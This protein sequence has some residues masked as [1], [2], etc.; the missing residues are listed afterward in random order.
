MNSLCT[1]IKTW[2]N[3]SQ[4]SRDGIGMNTS[5]RG[6][7]VKLFEQSQVLDTMLYKNM[8]FFSEIT[9]CRNKRP[10]LELTKL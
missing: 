3:A 8:P 7:S 6:S 4:R 5:P 10:G 9:F 1:V 2:L